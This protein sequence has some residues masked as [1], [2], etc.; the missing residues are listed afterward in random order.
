[1]GLRNMFE[2]YV[3]VDRQM[4]GQYCITVARN[5]AWTVYILGGGWDCARDVC[6]LGVLS[7]L[8][9]VSLF[10]RICLSCL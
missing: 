3:W 4:V 5:R 2:E 1:M 8:S 6:L 7:S 10:H 9:F